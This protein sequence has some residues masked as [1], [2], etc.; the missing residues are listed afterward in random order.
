MYVRIQPRLGFTPLRHRSREVVI[1][2]LVNHQHMI[3]QS[4]SSCIE[5]IILV[6]K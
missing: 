4:W 2:P 5:E 6:E 1:E 3:L